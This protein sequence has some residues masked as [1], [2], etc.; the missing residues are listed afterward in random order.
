MLLVGLLIGASFSARS[1]F[2]APMTITAL[3]KNAT[4]IYAG[5]EV[6]VA[7]VT[8]GAITAVEPAGAQVR[9]TLAVDRDVLI[10]SDARAVL[11]AQNLVSARY[12]QLAPAYHD[13][14][15]TMEAGV[16]IPVERTAVPIEWDEV[17]TQ[18]NRL[19]E[20]LGPKGGVS[21]TSVSRFVNSAA[22]A[23]DGNGDKLRRTLADLSGVGRI[24][25]DGSGDIA[26]ILANLQTFVSALRGSDVQLVEF[27]DQLATL[28]SVLDDNGGELEGALRNL[29]SAIDTVRN[30]V[31]GTRHQTAEQLQRLT[32]VTQN[33]V[34]HRTDLENVLHVA[35]NAL[36][37]VT[38]AYNPDTGTT[39]GSFALNNF[40]NPI[41]L[42]CGTIGAIE[43]VTAPETAKLC[44]Q[45]LGP[46]LNIANP[47]SILNVNNVPLPLNPYLQRSANPDNIIYTEPELAP[48]GLGPKPEQPE[49]IPD[50]SAYEGVQPGPPPYTG[51]PPGA[52]P[53]GAVPGAP[54]NTPATFPDMLLPEG[55]V[56]AA[57][58]P[59]TPLPAEVGAPG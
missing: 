35:P 31:S 13:A 26:E 36:A 48:G 41:Q 42:I 5:D 47:L 25:A 55:P 34:D 52:A 37:N 10:P 3:F 53:P 9:M 45:Y 23:M 22:T 56:G 12:V 18:L 43:N 24:L 46:A 7:G 30:F 6:K 16:E 1:A 21:G 33:L 58:L 17:K 29:S 50:V 54:P 40:A 57:P 15:P 14:G 27:G 32:N 28:T 59:A 38:N 39:I 2:F 8:V 44:N 51:R 11:V 49:K 19:A 20:E 4:G